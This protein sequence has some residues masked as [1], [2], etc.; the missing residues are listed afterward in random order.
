MIPHGFC[1]CGCGERTK[2]AKLT[3]N[4]IGIKAGQPNKYLAGHA[5]TR[6]GKSYVQG[7][8][9]FEHRMVAARALGRALPPRAQVHHVDGDRRNNT[10]SN[11]VI[12]ED[13]AYHKLLHARARIV[14]AGGD[15]NTERVCCRCQRVLSVDAFGRSN[16]RQLGTQGA[17]R[18]CMNAYRK[19]A[20]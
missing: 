9:D 18:Q 17:C 2:L 14:A 20:A 19:E 11:L 6:N 16:A 8:Q 3:N 5:R 12:C 15:P 4:R 1:H 7:G 13:M 10:P